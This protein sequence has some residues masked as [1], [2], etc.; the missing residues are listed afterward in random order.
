MVEQETIYVRQN[1][2]A[3]FCYT[4]NLRIHRN[5]FEK[6]SKQEKE[7]VYSKY[8]KLMNSYNLLNI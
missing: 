5:E 4:G 6:L 1:A 3:T 8:D 7:M 2:V